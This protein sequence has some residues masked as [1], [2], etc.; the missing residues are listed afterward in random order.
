MPTLPQPK[1]LAAVLAVAA[2]LAVPAAANATLSYNKDLK[3]PTVFYAKDNGKGAHKI[4]PG[5]NSHVSPDGKAVI[6][7][8][9]APDGIE[10]RLFSIATGKTKPL[11]NPWRE[12]YTSP[13][14]RIRP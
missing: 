4:G 1:L 6:Y 14:R 5:F 7:E 13:G 8:G 12:S 9:S 10:L 11:L 3:Q 2:L